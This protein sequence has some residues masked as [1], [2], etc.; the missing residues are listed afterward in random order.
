VAQTA[1]EILAVNLIHLMGQFP[2]LAPQVAVILQVAEDEDTLSV[3]HSQGGGHCYPSQLLRLA[4]LFNTPIERLLTVELQKVS[5]KLQQ[6]RFLILD[7]DGVM[8][9]GGMY[10]TDSG[11]EFKKFNTK[12][13]LIVR[14]LTKKGFPVGIASNG[15]LHNLVK[16]RADL[17]GVQKLYIGREQKAEIVSK[18]LKEMGIGWENVAYI[19]DDLNDEAMME[20]VGISACPADASVPIMNQ[21]DIILHKKGGEGCV[22]EFVEIYLAHLL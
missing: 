21:C 7:I 18:W 5:E 12:D 17:L 22:R 11:D 14:R 13:G 1:E 3:L 4:N 20:R 10:Y 19:G 6:I 9:D 16:R 8:T 15:F 2:E